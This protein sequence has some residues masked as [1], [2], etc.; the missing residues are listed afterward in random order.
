M[1]TVGSEDA[2]EAGQ[3]NPWF[4]YQGNQPGDE[5]QWLENHM[6]SAGW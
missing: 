6:G 2:M 5:I 3:I 4:R 1:L